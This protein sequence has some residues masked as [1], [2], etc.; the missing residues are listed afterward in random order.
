M[1]LAL[2]RGRIGQALA[3]GLTLLIPVTFALSVVAPLL[4]WYDERAEALLH[5]AMIARRM[6]AAASV[7]PT[8]QQQ[9]AAIAASGRGESALLEGE[10]DSMA[11]AWLQERLQTMFKQAGVQ[12][13]S[14]ETLPGEEAGP[15][16]RI[17]LRVSLN[18]AWPPLAAL[19]KELQLAEPALVV[20]ELDIVPAM[21]RIGTAPGTFDV[22]CAIFGFRSGTTQVS[23]R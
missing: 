16:R 8:L 22:S 13:N 20:D 17:R 14:V 10:S 23:V 18:T 21:H 12:L 3:L 4:E 7:L 1:K 9:A 11:S 6:E 19:L 5:R 15:Y 2:P